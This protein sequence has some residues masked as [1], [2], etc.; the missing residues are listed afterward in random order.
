MGLHVRAVSI[1]KT[2]LVLAL[3]IAG[4]HQPCSNGFSRSAD[5]VCRADTPCPSGSKRQKDLACHPQHST[6]E[7]QVDNDTGSGGI[8]S[9]SNEPEVD[10][11]ESEVDTGILSSGPGRIWASYEGLQGV[12]SHGFIVYGTLTGQP[13]PV[14]VFCQI[15]LTDP[16]TVSGY[17]VPFDN[18][19]DPC[20]STGEAKLFDPGNVTLTMAV[21][22]N[23]LSTPALCDERAVQID[24]D[25]IVDFSDVIACD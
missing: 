23:P 10:T 3:P 22:E 8:D 2:S 20:P 25:Q 9:G 7:L 15:I 6:P 4:C 1:L 11:A 5:G 17:L 24:G 14:A 18:Q 16:M 21:N 19:S 13:D 12:L